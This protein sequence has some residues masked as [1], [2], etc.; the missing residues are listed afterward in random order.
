MVRCLKLGMRL[1]YY[2]HVKKFRLFY[3]H[4]AQ[5]T[6]LSARLC[7]DSVIY[8][9][10]GGDLVMRA[11]RYFSYIVLVSCFLINFTTREVAAETASCPGNNKALGV[12]RTVEIDTT[13][14]PGFGFQ[15][16]KSYDFLQNGE[17]VLTFDDG[18]LPNRTDKILEALA[19]HCTKATFFPVGKLAVGYPELLK[20]LADGG[21]TIGSH[22]WS[23]KNLAKKK[24]KVAESEIER[25][26][27]AVSLA[28]GEKQSPFFRFPYL[29]D[30]EPLVKYLGE[31]NIAIFSTDLDSFD[32]KTKSQNRLITNIVKKLKKRKKGILLLHDI[33]PVTVK[34]MPKL[35][36][37]L[38]E[39]G[40]KIVHLKS[41]ESAKSLP[42]FEAIVKKE[43]KGRIANA[44]GRP[45]SSVVK[46]VSRQEATAQ[47]N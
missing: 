2:T 16:Y 24:S 21:H 32:F 33:Q 44:G 19:H 6:E 39:S 40:F 22:T 5:C 27:S 45:M 28:I 31:R 13:A 4:L 34:A 14:G 37:A 35:L 8:Q 25:G 36:D 43:F 42:N 47:S 23:H 10:K 41:K 29:K 3:D 15:H 11:S 38:K 20:Q 1:A 17:V 9:S 26:L 18:P 46:T 12:S 7:I 30:S